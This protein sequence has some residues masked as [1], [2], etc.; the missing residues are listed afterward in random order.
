MLRVVAL[1]SV[2]AAGLAALGLGATLRLYG[3]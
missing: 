3:G 1:S 2:A